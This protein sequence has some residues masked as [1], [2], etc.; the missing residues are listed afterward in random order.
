MYI[1]KRKTV[2]A[3]ALIMGLLM[4]GETSAEG[5]VKADSAPTPEPTATVEP[6]V[7]PSATPIPTVEPTVAPVPEITPTPTPE[8]RTTK[9]T[10]SLSNKKLKLKKGTKK[11]LKVYKAKGKVKWSS[12]NKKV[13]TVT[14]KGV[15]KA[16]K[17]GT[18]VIK[19]KCSGR[20]KVLKCKVT[21]YKKK[22]TTS[23]ITK[24]VLALKKTY[25]EGTSWGDNKFYF[26]KAIN[27]NC[28]GCI[29]FAGTVSD[30]IFGKNT[31]VKQH[32]DF[33][34]IKPGDHVRIGDYHSLI[35]ISKKGNTVTVVEGNYNKSVHWGRKFTKS[36]LQSE[37]FYV[38]T[39]Y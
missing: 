26:W 28:Y 32:K 34:K 19:V 11:K 12:S 16:K 14:Q 23:T 31:P 17:T 33:S 15:V 5:R 25:P 8:V 6:T 29:A 3:T 10:Y 13:A 24:K 27:C 2:I 4:V 1:M 22:V 9:K 7:E 38:E 18:A 37:G 35:V 21:V 30:A 36:K 39:R 20:K